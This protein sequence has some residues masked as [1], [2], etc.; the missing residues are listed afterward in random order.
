MTTNVLLGFPF[1]AISIL[2]HAFLLIFDPR[3]SFR[4]YNVSLLIWIV[5][6][7]IWMTTEFV[8]EPPSSS[9]HLGPAVPL[10]GLSK[11]TIDNM[12]NA[13]SVLFLISSSVQVLMYMLIFFRVISMPEDDEEDMVSKN[14]AVLFFYGSQPYSKDMQDHMALDNSD[15]VHIISLDGVGDERGNGSNT[16]PSY[17][18]SL[19]FIENG[20]ILF[21]ILKDLCWSCG[22]GDLTNDQQTAIAFESLAMCCGIVSIFI[23]ALTSYLYRRNTLRFLDA[24]TTIFW[25]AANFV[26]MA[27]E[28][29]LRYNN[30][31]Y[32]DQTQGNDYD[33]RIASATLFL[34][35]LLVQAY[36]VL[37]VCLS[38]MSAQNSIIQPSANRYRGERSAVE[39]MSMSNVVV[40]LTF[41]P[42]NHHTNVDS[43]EQEV[44]KSCDNDGSKPPLIAG[45]FFKSGEASRFGKHQRLA[46]LDENE[47]EST[48]LF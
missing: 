16:G 24:I 21:W 12:V 14:E 22:T 27:G 37:A 19:I 33:T 31:E 4:F 3:K 9:V 8:A 30:L 42:L 2:L 40:S 38:V 11:Q 45:K 29:F 5:G 47:D 23:Y 10:G 25:I 34:L 7:F 39:L 1:G 46:V 26:W 44:G 17:G 32:D 18:F 28:F 6:N 48:V 20:Y 36:I 35:G 13:K 41:N 15:D 43:S